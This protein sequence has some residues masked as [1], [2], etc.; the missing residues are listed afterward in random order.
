[1]YKTVKI[2]SAFLHSLNETIQKLQING[3]IT[4]ASPVT[5]DKDGNFTSVLKTQTD[6]DP[7]QMGSNVFIN[8]DEEDSQ[9]D[10]NTKEKLINQ[11]AEAIKQSLDASEDLTSIL[12]KMKELSNDTNYNQWQVNEEGNTATLKSKDARIF[13]QN[14]KLCLSHAGKIELFD[15]VTQL[16]DW[17][18]ENNYPLPGNIEIHESVE[19]EES[20]NWYDLIDDKSIIR[21]GK[22]IKIG[23]TIEIDPKEQEELNLKQ[24]YAGLRN[25]S[26][27]DYKQAMKFMDK[28]DLQQPK[29]KG[30]PTDECFGGTTTASLGTATTWTGKP[31]KKEEDLKEDVRGIPPFEDNLFKDKRKAASFWFDWAQKNPDK[32]TKKQYDLAMEYRKAGLSANDSGKAFYDLFEKHGISIKNLT[33]PG[34]YEK[35]AQ[36]IEEL[37]TEFADFGF[38]MTPEEPYK[39]IVNSAGVVIANIGP[40]NKQAKKIFQQDIF[41]TLENRR[42]TGVKG[43]TQ[44]FIPELQKNLDAKVAAEKQAN[45]K[46]NLSDEIIHLADNLVKT[47]DNYSPTEFFNKVSPTLKKLSNVEKEYVITQLLKAADGDS[48]IID[49]SEFEYNVY[50]DM[51]TK[52][53]S[54]IKESVNHSS[55]FAK[56]IGTTLKEEDTP[57]DFATGTPINNTGTTTPANQTTTATTD[58]FSDIDTNSTDTTPS[59]APEFGDINISGGSGY[60]PEG[61]DE[62]ISNITPNTPQYEI[63]DVLVNDDDASDIKVK[64]K[65]IE[66]DKI[67][68]KDLA[69]IDV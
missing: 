36:R 62:D 18:K 1:M 64:V 10:I 20:R 55:K 33:E 66:T 63:V 41:P 43:K 21:N 14:D 42:G 58:D 59:V 27:N 38:K 31:A 2:N 17:L 7:S 9:I 37:N 45:Q 24:S 15:N 12:R 13:K 30:L 40:I 67:E 68:I 39:R 16:H 26:T 11:A 8:D 47:H 69:E 6:F 61:D 23:D 44:K 52:T 4:E 51:L 46:L 57:A 65:N 3:L 29:I 56:I 54:V 50:K 28:K 53:E 48:P 5:T 25:M 49:M 19:I 22:E 34:G 35:Y 60:A 32:V